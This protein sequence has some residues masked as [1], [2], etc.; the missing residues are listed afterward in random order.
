MARIN[1]YLKPASNMN[2]ILLI[3]VPV[4]YKSLKESNTLKTIRTMKIQ[5]YI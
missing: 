3:N 2:F 1:K 5:S 4:K